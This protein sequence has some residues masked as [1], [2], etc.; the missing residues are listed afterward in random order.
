V[1][2]RK[3]CPNK[4]TTSAKELAQ[5]LGIDPLEILLHFAN[6]DWKALGYDSPTLLKITADGGHEVDRISAEMRVMAAKEAAKYIYPT[7]KAVEFTGDQPQIKMIIEDYTRK[8]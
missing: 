5:K 6:K 1:A 4:I 2:S 8:S 7:Q 3:G